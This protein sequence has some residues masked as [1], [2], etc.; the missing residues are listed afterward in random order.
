MTEIEERGA[1][2]VVDEAIAEALDGPDAIYLSLDIDVIDPGLAPGTG[3]PEPGGMLTREVLR[4]VR[5][6]VGAVPLAAMD[7]VEVAPPYDHAE[8]TAMAAHRAVLEAISALAVR[9]RDGHTVRHEIVSPQDMPEFRV[10][11]EVIDGELAR[12]SATSG[13]V[14]RGEGSPGGGG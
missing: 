11:E 9:K 6:I 3:T 12:G 13:A 10:G 2:A 8:V 14:L 1:E 7:V 5:R 4:A